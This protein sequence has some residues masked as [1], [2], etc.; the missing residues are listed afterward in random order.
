MPE[1]PG[2]I[3]ASRPLETLLVIAVI[4]VL[5]IVIGF[6]YKMTDRYMTALKE[7][8]QEF[9]AALSVI[10]DKHNTDVMNKLNEIHNDM[11]RSRASKKGI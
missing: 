5:L 8:R 4:G 6:V 2:E 9:T 10:V 3:A 1:I 7:Q 11:P